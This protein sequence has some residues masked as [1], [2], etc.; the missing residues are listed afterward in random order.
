MNVYQVISAFLPAAP[1]DA[2]VLNSTVIGVSHAE[3][4]HSYFKF[5]NTFE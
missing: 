4:T 5:L 1:L 2:C 3:K